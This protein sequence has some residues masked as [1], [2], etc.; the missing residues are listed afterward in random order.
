MCTLYPRVSA[1]VLGRSAPGEEGFNIAAK[2]IAD[3]VGGAVALAITGLLFGGESFWAVFAFSA[4]VGVAVVLIAR[5]TGPAPSPSGGW[6]PSGDRP[7]SEGS[8]Q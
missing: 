7:R 2:G 1:L 5:R 6:L 4:A 8:G 3:S